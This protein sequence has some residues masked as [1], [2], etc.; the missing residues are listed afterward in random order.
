MRGQGSSTIEVI[1][2]M[3][4]FDKLTIDLCN[5]NALSPPLFVQMVLVVAN[6]V[7]IVTNQTQ[8]QLMMVTIV[9][10]V[11]PIS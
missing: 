4:V 7:L 9:V 3:L 11:P 2:L 1:H 5:L 10:R 6:L 8:F